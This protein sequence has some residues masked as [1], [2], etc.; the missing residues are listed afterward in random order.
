MTYN[1]LRFS[2]GKYKDGKRVINALRAEYM[3]VVE[4]SFCG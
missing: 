3:D 1:V 4:I 2:D